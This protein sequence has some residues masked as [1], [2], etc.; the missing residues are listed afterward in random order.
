MGAHVIVKE[1]AVSLSWLHNKYKLK[2]DLVIQ[3]IFVINT[4]FYNKYVK[5]YKNVK[6]INSFGSS[7]ADQIELF[8]VNTGIKTITC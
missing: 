6:Q 5:I 2:T 8:D 3:F 7:W 4:Q 1:Q